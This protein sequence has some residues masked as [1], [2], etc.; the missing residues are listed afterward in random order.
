MFGVVAATRLLGNKGSGFFT[1]T[2]SVGSKAYSEIPALTPK[3]SILLSP[4]AMRYE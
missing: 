2:I 1:A 3:E 4:V